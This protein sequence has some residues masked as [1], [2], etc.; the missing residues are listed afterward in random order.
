LKKTLQD[1]TGKYLN[2]IRIEGRKMAWWNSGAWGK[3]TYQCERK[4]KQK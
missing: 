2:V 1:T 3:K 4:Q